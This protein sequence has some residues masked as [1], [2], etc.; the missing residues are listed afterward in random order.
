MDFLIVYEVEVV[1]DAVSRL[2][3][4]AGIIA[5]LDLQEAAEPLPSL[6][7]VIA[8]A[9]P[10]AP[11]W[12]R[13]QRDSERL[14]RGSVDERNFHRKRFLAGEGSHQERDFWQ[15]EISAGEGSHPGERF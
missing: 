1:E 8:Q 4:L 12:N 5:S 15:G 10:P 6:F 7:Q 11:P 13:D 2:R 3:H 14:Q 9:L